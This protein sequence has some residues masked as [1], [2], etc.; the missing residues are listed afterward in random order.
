MHGRIYMLSTYHCERANSELKW[1]SM[2]RKVRLGD[3]MCSP[4]LFDRKWEG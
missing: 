1:R 2:A 3:I 4:A